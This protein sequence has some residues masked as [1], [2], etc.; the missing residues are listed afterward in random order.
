MSKFKS[1]F[2]VDFAKAL[3]KRKVKFGYE[4]T[5]FPF[6]QPSKK[7]NYTPD[8]ELLG[9]G[10]FVECKGKLTVAEREKLLWIKESYPD[11]R[12]VLVFMRGRNPI[13]KGSKTSYMD[14][15]T[16]NGFEAFDWNSDTKIIDKI[17]KKENKE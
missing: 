16:K 9:T 8:F 4:T 13:R 3:K 15:A 2:E 14:W 1:G 12:L 17:N 11:L 6:V 5:K 10:T 7:R